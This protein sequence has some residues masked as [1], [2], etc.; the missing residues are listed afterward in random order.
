MRTSYLLIGYA[1]LLIAG[2]LRAFFSAPDPSRATTA[3]IVPGICA[4]LVLVVAWW[5]RSRAKSE[6]PLGW[7]HRVAILL[8][9]VFAAG[10]GMQAMKVSK[11]VTLHKDTTAAWQAQVEKAPPMDPRADREA[12][13]AARGAPVRDRSYQ[14]GALVALTFVSVLTF[15]VLVFQRRLGETPVPGEPTVT[16]SA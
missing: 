12:F 14:L 1:V 13:F 3:L 9:L 5:V 4:A 16:P 7:A 2:G 8:P 10:I 6:R 15:G 11:A